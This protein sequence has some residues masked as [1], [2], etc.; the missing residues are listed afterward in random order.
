MSPGNVARDSSGT[1]TRSAF[2]E[3]AETTVDRRERAEGEN[4]PSLPQKTNHSKSGLG[5]PSIVALV[6]VIDK[7]WT[8]LERHE[9]HFIPLLRNLSMIASRYKNNGFHYGERIFLHPQRILVRTSNEPT[10][11]KRNEF[12]E[13]YAIANEELYPGCD[14][15]T[16]LDFMAK[17]TNFKVKGKLIDS[18]F[19]EMLEF[20]Q[21]VFPTTKGY[22]LPPSYYAIKKTFKTIGLGY[23]SIHACVN[24]YFLFWGDNNKDVHFCPCTEPGKMQHPIDGKAWKNFDTKYPNFAKEPRN[25]RLGLAAA[26]FNQFA[27]LVCLQYCGSGDIETSILPPWLCM[28]ESSFMLTLLIPGPKSPGKDID[29]YLRPL[30]DDLNVEWARLQ[31]MPYMRS[32]EFNGE[33]EDG[34]PPRK[35]DRD[36]I[37]AQLARLPT[38]VKGKHPR[39][40]GVKIKRNV[41]VELNWTKQSIFYE[42]EYWSFLTLKHNLD[43]MHIE[44]NVLEAILNTLLMNG[45]S[46]GTRQGKT[47]LEKRNRKKFCQ[48][49]KGVKLPD[50]FGSCF[51]HKVTDNDTNITG[52]KSHDCHIMMQRLLPYGLQNYLPDKIAKPIIELCSLF[53]QICSTTLMEDDMLKAQIKVVD[54]LCDLELIYPPALFDIMIHLVIHLPLEALEGGPIRPRWMFPFE[55]YMKKLKGYVRNK[56]KPEGSIAEGYVA[57]E[58]LTFSSHYFRDVTTK[59]NRLDRNVDPPPPTCQF[60]VFRSVCKS[61]GLRSVIRFDAQELKKVKWYVLH[62]SPEIDTYRSQFK[63]K[64]PNKDMKEEFLD[65]FGSQIRQRHVDNDLVLAR[66][67]RRTTQNS[68]ICSPGGKDGE[69]YY[70]RKVKH[71]VLRNNMTQILKKDETFKDDLYILATQVKQCFYLED[72]ARRQPHWKVVEHVNHKKFSDGGVI[73]V[74]EDPDVIHFDN[75]S[76]LPLSTSLN[77]L[78][79]ATLHIDGQST[80]V[81]A[82]PDI[83]DLDEDDDIIDDE[84]ALPHDLADSDDEDLVNV[85]D[86]D[87]VDVMSADVA[88]GHDGDSGGDDRPL[89]HHTPTGCEGC[90][91]NRGGDEEGWRQRNLTDDEINRLARS[92]SKYSDMF[93]QFE[94]GG[95]SGSGGCKDDEESADDQEDEDEDGDGDKRKLILDCKTRWNSTYYMLS[96]AI[97]FK[98]AFSMYELRDPSYLHCPTSD[99]WEKIECICEILEAFDSCTNIISGS[100][101]PTLNRFFGEVQYIKQ[102]LDKRSMDS[103][104]FVVKMVEEMKLKFDKY[105]G[106][107]N[108]LMCIA[109]ILDPRCKFDMLRFYFKENFDEKVIEK[110]EEVKELLRKICKE[111]SLDVKQ[112]SSGSDSNTNVI[113][114][115]HEAISFNILEWWKSRETVHILSKL[116]ALM[117]AIPVTTVASEVTCSAG[118]R[119]IDTYRAS[120]KPKTVQA[121]TCG[122]DWVRQLHGVKKKNKKCYSD[123]PLVVPLEGLQVDDKLHFVEEPV[124]IMDREVKQL[125]RSRVPI[126]KV[127]WNSRRGPEFTWERED[128]FRKKYPHLFTKTAPSSS[129]V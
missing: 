98:D 2:T 21:H 104:N 37:Q 107:C 83:I 25:I 4:E 14:Y 68:G 52:L 49:I 64:F 13:L 125:R 46:K 15:V 6:M 33:I 28:K 56:A 12:E 57:E 54:I 42:L 105:W 44:K 55:R 35:F 31:G 118:G 60:Q 32:L 58:A 109:C 24:D 91:A 18:I 121:L 90:F 126:V 8:L 124:E 76:D 67:E 39:H 97:I 19:N 75:S 108:M 73:V 36:Q 20:F 11:A 1:K 115:I 103:C 122:G 111:S 81:D 38:R 47:R 43:I 53:K 128:Q 129:A 74:E 100:D 78:D 61:I 116:A 30:I 65:W 29:V 40:V 41:R 23:E 117:L 110:I 10:Q 113:R 120:L 87:G 9:N 102:L 62:N 51:K 123:D 106:E 101:Y 70:G 80:E 16:R 79:N 22:K 127:R 5:L 114:D 84:D 45:E 3:V 82:P 69:M 48:F 34:D 88:R 50:G 17:F 59:F 99:D 93:S 77:D 71:L 86:D 26:G 63:S 66:N 95:A 119:V 72:M 27:T 112:E 96:T 89:T 85:D 7:S 94:S 92:D